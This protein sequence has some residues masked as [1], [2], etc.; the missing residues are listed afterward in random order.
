M[1]SVYHVMYQFLEQYSYV[2]ATNTHTYTYQHESV[3]LVPYVKFQSRGSAVDIATG[4]GLDDGGA[5]IRVPL[6]LRI[7]TSPYCPDW[8]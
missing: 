2:Y 4:Y 5:G 1:I 7:F 6:R 3:I 8:L